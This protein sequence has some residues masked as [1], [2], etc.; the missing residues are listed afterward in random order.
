VLRLVAYA[1][2]GVRRFPITRD[3]LVIGSLPACDIVLPYTGVARRHARVL[4]DGAVLR[5][6]DLGSRRG[7]LVDGRRV[8][9]A[10]LRVLD[11]VK[12]G[13]V[14]L[15]VEDVVPEPEADGGPQVDERPPAGPP[16]MT[17]AR[18]VEHLARISHWVLADAESRTTLE[19]LTENLL[20]DFGGG[21]LFLFVGDTEEA[22]IKFVSATDPAWMAAGE[23]LLEQLGQRGHVG[24][25]AERT[26]FFEGR[27]G[28]EPA[29]LFHRVFSALDRPYF[30]VCALA[31][32][33]PDPWSPEAALDTLGDLLSL[34][35]VHH[36][37][38]YEPILPGNRGVQDLT[39][40][41]GLVVGESR[42]LKE[43]LARMRAA[44]DTGVHVL[45]RGEPGVGRELLARSIH[46][47]SPQ[48][49]GPFIVA[50]AAGANPTQVEADLFGSEV[51]ARSGA[52]KREGKI[53][54]A[55]GGT[56]FLD[57]VERLPLE[58]QARL[59]RFL[60][61]G[62]VEPAGSR[63]VH[64]VA[65][66]LVAASRQPL[67]P[68][69]ARDEFR[70]DLAYRLSRF[71]IDVPPLRE[72]K[73]DLPLLIQSF[74]NRF[75]HET[76]KRVAGITTKAMTALLSYPYPGNLEELENIARQMVYLCPHNRPADV[77]LL[78]EAVKASPLQ[79]SARVEAT[80][81]LELD[82]LVAGAEETAIR[83]AIRR[84]QG[85][86]SQAARLLGISRN[87]LAT[88]ME[89]YG[90]GG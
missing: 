75:C 22:G 52:V 44:V 27:L 65:V 9:E 33:D 2:D 56:L 17:P 67:E 76:G 66:R 23:Q 15:L 16:V 81:D 62:E 21:A 47:S 78:P 82:R 53:R 34:G 3:E 8:K 50:S 38:R 85:N 64:H 89:K 68:A 10:E 71:V 70:V 18:M 19:S 51:A 74:V 29:W 39:L 14:T 48:R 28:N 72:R 32:F 83:E 1:P 87:T 77:S 6:E 43:V 5:V 13:G 61:S 57:D 63:E 31:R 88:K 60:R 24:T 55:D 11:E 86:K 58:L 41:P 26:W 30:M 35:L 42:G 46:L 79:A 37:G 12:V 84:T 49:N 90:I 40:D 25:G 36:V 45:L 20:S 59:V 54:L 7:L 4:F 80:S 69:V 73:E